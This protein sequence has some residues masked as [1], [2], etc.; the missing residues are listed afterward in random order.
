MI[1]TT[2]SNCAQAWCV[3]PIGL[4][5]LATAL[6]ASMASAGAQTP[7]SAGTLQQQIERDQ[8]GAQPRP[9]APPRGK[10]APEAPPVG[11]TVTVRSFKFKG[12]T[13]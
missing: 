2:V 4:H 12:N 3:H 1:P 8:P 6:A 10:A 13:L 11:Q 7:P 5:L 9:Q